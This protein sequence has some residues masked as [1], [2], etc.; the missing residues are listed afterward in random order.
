M[1]KNNNLSELRIPP[2][3]LESEQ[4]VL[5]ALMLRPSAIHEITDLIAPE[6]F[7][8]RKHAT[9]FQTMLELSAKSEPIDVLSVASKLKEKKQINEVGGNSYLNEIMGNVP[10][11]VNIRHYADIVYKKH[12]LRSLI[13]L[14]YGISTSIYPSLILR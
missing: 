13:S 8:A 3:S 9:I 4:A 10:S 5:G 12:I 2:H 7:Y 14:P 11:T 6:M 1:V